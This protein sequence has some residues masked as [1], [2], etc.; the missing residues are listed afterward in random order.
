MDG[1]VYKGAFSAF[2]GAKLQTHKFVNQ[3][4][5]LNLKG[6]SSLL[7]IYGIECLTKFNKC[8]S[9]WID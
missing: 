3:T 1:L 9:Y 7:V 2:M 4:Y 8:I 6:L 5:R